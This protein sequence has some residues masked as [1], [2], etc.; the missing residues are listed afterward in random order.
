M[1][2]PRF[3]RDFDPQ[4]GTAVR[5]SDRVRRVTANNPGPFTFHGTNTFL[6]GDRSMAIIDPG[7]DDPA[8]VEAVMAAVG[9]REVSHILVTHTH[10]D[11]SPASAAIK[12]RTGAPIFA[13]GPHR[14]ARELALG[15]INP[16]D[17]SADLGFDPDVRV[18][19]G[20]RIEGDGWAFKA[21]ATP[22]HTANHFAFALEGEDILFVGD[23]VMAWSTSIVA[24]PDGSMA[25]YMRS[26]DHLMVRGDARLL[27]GHGG[28][29]TEVPD[30]LAG[31][32]RH[33]EG[34]EAAVLDQ[35]THGPQSIL[36]MVA[37]IYSDVDKSLHPAASLSML[38][39][40]EYLVERGLVQASE[41][42]SLTAIF[43]LV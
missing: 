30:F 43:K 35:L 26:L 11:H 8:H 13:E 10:R 40:L 6:V 29:V 23:H 9:D 34:R 3:N 12:A 24:P 21:V 14:P 1:T 5:E 17:A 20:D 15:E 28:P 42:P 22:G 18:K 19:H 36:D 38:A 25:D 7:P 33:R 27:S 37:T 32:K 4:H 41:P 39:Q 31:L 2:G 16:L